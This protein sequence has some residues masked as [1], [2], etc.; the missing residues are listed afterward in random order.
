MAFSLCIHIYIWQS[1]L[2]DTSKSS[3][4]L[5]LY[6]LSYHVMVFG[7]YRFY[8]H[9]KHLLTMILSFLLLLL[10]TRLVGPKVN[11]FIIPTES[12]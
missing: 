8:L 11:V 2:Y 9:D 7:Y 4:I 10:H 6:S 5:F 12:G 3:V 1:T